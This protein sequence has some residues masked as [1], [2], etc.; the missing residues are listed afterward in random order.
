MKRVLIVTQY[1]YPEIFRSTD[2]ALEMQKRGY[3]VDVL[4]S[5]PNYPAGKY[6]SGYGVFKRR[7]EN[8]DGVKIYRAFQFARGSHSGI[9][10]ILNYLSYAFCASFWALGFAFRKKYDAIIVHATSPIFQ[11][12]PAVL[13]SKLRDIP[14][15]TWV[16]DIWPDALKSAGGIKS[17]A[18]IN[19]VDRFVHWVYSNSRRVL[20]SSKDFLPLLNRGNHDYTSKTDYFPNW[21]DDIR[22]MT[23]P[24]IASLGAGFK[25]MMA[26]NLGTAQDIR[27][28]ME[29]VKLTAHVPEIKW[30]FV[31]DGSEKAYIEEFVKNYSLEDTVILTGKVP[32]EHIPS[33]YAQADVMLLTLRARFPH[34]NAVV[35]ARLQ[36]YMAA[37][38]P[39]L[40][41]VNG[42]SV[43]VIRES[44]C[45]VTVEAGDYTALA[46]AALSLYNDRRNL[47]E[48]GANA[49]EY[50]QRNFTKELCI[51]NLENII[52]NG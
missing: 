13:L 38:K 31:G 2:I 42:G 20:I 48:M 51:N 41:M 9:K 7:Y 49:Y 18:I 10:L 15:Y 44:N 47:S 36:S 11:A 30:V 28:V 3:Q 52:N 8:L 5:I 17:P 1:F 21:C 34:L 46:Q 19:S 25:I 37:G 40:G 27:N 45:G 24:E 43:N 39:I 12:L 22:E 23:K 35:P 4:T 50:Y 14:V 16:L 33:Y 29:A 6:Y 26:G 32:F